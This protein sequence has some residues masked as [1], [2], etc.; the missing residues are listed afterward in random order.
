MKAPD[1]VA[2]DGYM[3]CDL[4]I[5]YTNEIC[6]LSRSCIYIYQTKVFIYSKT[7]TKILQKL[8]RETTQ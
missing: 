3:E 1:E 4:C 5:R 2:Y 6:I 7:F 8:L